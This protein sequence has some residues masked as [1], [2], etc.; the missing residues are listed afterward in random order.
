MGKQIDEINIHIILYKVVSLLVS[1]TVMAL[2]IS[3]IETLT[4]INK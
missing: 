1:F 4:H 2:H 3:V